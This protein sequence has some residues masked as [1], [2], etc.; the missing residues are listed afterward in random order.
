MFLYVCLFILCYSL[1]QIP[2]FF[3]QPII[4][5]LFK[6]L[7]I[8]I[9]LNI[10]VSIVNFIL[11]GILGAVLDNIVNDKLNENAKIDN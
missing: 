9:F 1:N 2:T 11:Y 3:K 5:Y 8:Y 4:I 6:L 10:L 7:F